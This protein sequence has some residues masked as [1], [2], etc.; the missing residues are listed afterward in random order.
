[1]FPTKSFSS[2]PRQALEGLDFLE[3]II[4][5]D[6]LT[7]KTIERSTTLESLEKSGQERALNKPAAFD[8]YLKAIRPDDLATIIYTSGTTGEPK[9]VMLT[10]ANFIS[11]VLTITG[12]FA[13]L[14]D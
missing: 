6:D 4:F 14:V 1:M 5:F 7:V 9:G 3:K 10:H 13:H 12:G 2:T 8:A 11:N